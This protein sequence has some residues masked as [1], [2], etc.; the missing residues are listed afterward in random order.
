M[1][2]KLVTCSDDVTNHANFSNRRLLQ[3][4][5]LFLTGNNWEYCAISYVGI[6][7]GKHCQIVLSKVFQMEWP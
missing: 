6:G 2:L 7:K 3:N 4:L 1:L 5:V